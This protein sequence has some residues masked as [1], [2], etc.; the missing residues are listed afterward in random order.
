[1]TYSAANIEFDKMAT[2]RKARIMDIFEQLCAE[3]VL[4]VR[5]AFVAA[6]EDECKAVETERV[7]SQAQGATQ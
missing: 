6:V 3:N 1:M 5:D 2:D 7:I 4:N